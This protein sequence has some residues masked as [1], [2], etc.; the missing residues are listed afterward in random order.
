MFWNAEFR[1]P[2]RSYAAYAISFRKI[3]ITLLS[4]SEKNE[5]LEANS[6]IRL[7]NDPRVPAIEHHIDIVEFS[8]EVIRGPVNPSNALVA[9]IPHASNIVSFAQITSSDLG[10]RSL[11]AIKAT[12]DLNTAAEM[13]PDSSRNA[14]RERPIAT[15]FELAWRT[16]Y[17]EHGARALVCA[18]RQKRVPPTLLET[19]LRWNPYT[20]GPHCSYDG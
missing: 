13:D 15:I 4:C 12:A 6:P 9:C 5:L 2:S 18:I 19:S 20:L 1:E 14:Q 7:I 16:L 8:N 11:E 10:L 3:G 17:S